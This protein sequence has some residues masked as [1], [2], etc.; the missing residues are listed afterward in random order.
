MLSSTINRI[1]AKAKTLKR[2]LYK[3]YSAKDIL[4][5]QKGYL[6]VNLGAGLNWRQLNWVGLD[7]LDGEYLDENSILPFKDKSIKYVYS[8]HFFEHISD[9]CA[10]NLFQEIKR[11][12]R[13]DG[14]CRIVVPDFEALHEAIINDDIT[15][16]NYVGFK[17]RI[18]WEKFGLENNNLNRLLHWF[19]NYTNFPEIDHSLILKDKIFR[20][21]P[22]ISRN[23][24][25]DKAKNMNTLQ[26][27]EWAISKID[28]KFIVNGGHIN[29]WT[30]DKCSTV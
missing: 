24:L 29:T 5:E 13:P 22:I 27:G 16:M 30:S 20:G 26:F 12:L 1:K 28:P 6:G 7:K 8:S 14:L 2:G 19:A 10:F 21:P 3:I 23:E 11:I 4:I 9:A 18:E 25:L 17:G 15:L